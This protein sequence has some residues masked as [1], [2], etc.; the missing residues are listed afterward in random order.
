[1]MSQE[2]GHNLL[3]IILDQRALKNIYLAQ[4]EVYFVFQNADSHHQ[5]SLKTGPRA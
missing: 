2:K 5:A 3:T 1:M 4:T